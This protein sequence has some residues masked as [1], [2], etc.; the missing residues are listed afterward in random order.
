MDVSRSFKTCCKLFELELF[1]L[2]KTPIKFAP[3]L[4]LSEPIEFKLIF[5]TVKL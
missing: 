3:E 4:A 2:S 1:K 5:P